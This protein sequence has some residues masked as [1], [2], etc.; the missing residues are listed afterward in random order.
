MSESEK[1]LCPRDIANIAE[2]EVVSLPQR[3][4]S[5]LLCLSLG[6]HDDEGNVAQKAEQAGERAAIAKAVRFLGE[7]FGPTYEMAGGDMGETLTDA[8][9]ALC[10]EITQIHT[11]LTQDC[12][13]V[14]PALLR[15]LQS[16]AVTVLSPAVAAFLSTLFDNVV[17]W[18]RASA[19][20]AKDVDSSALSQIDAIS[21]QINF[22]AINASVEAARVG[23][24]GRGFGVIA[25]EIKQ[26]SER[27]REAVER[28]RSSVI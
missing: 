10:A 24:A 23:E 8:A 11:E 2:A 5:L 1:S 20:L 4:L 22:I 3:V 14:T 18:E 6:Q 21:R 7:K 12:D 9:E 13:D 27:S 17:M 15:D 19:K 28:V 26:L 16:R 25:A